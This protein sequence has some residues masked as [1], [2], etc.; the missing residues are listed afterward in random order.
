M[1]RRNRPR[2]SPPPPTI[3]EFSEDAVVGLVQDAFAKEAG[4]AGIQYDPNIANF[5]R[6]ANDIIKKLS[7]DIV[8]G[9][10]SAKTPEDVRKLF[11]DAAAKLARERADIL[12]KAGSLGL[13]PNAAAAIRT[14]LL[15]LNKTRGIDLDAIKAAAPDLAGL[16]AEIASLIDSNAPAADVFAKIGEIQRAAANRVAK[17]LEGKG[18]EVGPDE[19]SSMGLPMEF[20]AIDAVEGLTDKLFAFF[21]RED[22]K[23]LDFMDVN[24]PAFDA[25]DTHKAIADANQLNIINA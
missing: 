4:L 18:G 24:S 12:R 10:T 23:D 3:A 9:K 15:T 19:K 14:H 2:P 21:G 22:V 20:F 25:Y 5:G 7:L 1:R 13:S 8:D 16:V 6:G 17:M 11:K